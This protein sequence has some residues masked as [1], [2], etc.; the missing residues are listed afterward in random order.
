M[1]WKKR[2]TYVTIAVRNGRVWGRGGI[3]LQNADSCGHVAFQNFS[4]SAQNTTAHDGECHFVFRS[5]FNLG[6]LKFFLNF[7]YV[8]LTVWTALEKMCN[9]AFFR[10]FVVELLLLFRLQRAFNNRF[11]RRCTTKKCLP[12][13]FCFV[14]L[15]FVFESANLYFDFSGVS[16]FLF[17]WISLLG[18]KHNRS[19]RRSNS[20]WKPSLRKEKKSTST[21]VK[22]ERSFWVCVSGSASV[23]VVLCDEEGEDSIGREQGEQLLLGMV[24][25]SRQYTLLKPKY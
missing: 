4:W 24:T 12:L 23:C 15:H 11:F 16:V 18:S 25:T 8:F 19:L 6:F 17:F 5:S 9:V 20:F 3:L 13:F 21:P 22:A 14:L 1:H 7:R 2:C 10:D